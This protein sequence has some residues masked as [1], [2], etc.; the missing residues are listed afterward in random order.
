MPCCFLDNPEQEF[1]KLIDLG[2]VE[3]LSNGRY[4]MHMF[5]TAYATARRNEAER[6]EDI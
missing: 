4:Q 6:Y 2:L 3:R 1:A 5:W